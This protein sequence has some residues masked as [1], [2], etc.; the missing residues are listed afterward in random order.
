MENEV[1][2]KS[3]K[4]K[5]VI[6]NKN[7]FY[8]FIGIIIVIILL[9]V[10]LNIFSNKKIIVD[11]NT[12]ISKINLNKHSEELKLYYEGLINEF[13]VEYNNVQNMSWTYIYN[14]IASDKTMEELIDDVNRIFLSNDWS[15]LGMEKNIKW[16]G[17][18][19]IDK[20]NNTLTF[21]F[22]SKNIEPSWID[23]SSVSHMIM[24]N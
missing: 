15:S 2:K 10:V 6:K 22:E 14:N 16:R 11:N 21:K 17:S 9:I 1:N 8:K 20:S 18:Y 5:V 12:N 3:K 13:I 19:E 7:K 23:D 4:L 24:K